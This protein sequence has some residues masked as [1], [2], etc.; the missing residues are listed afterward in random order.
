MLQSARWA[1]DASYEDISAKTG[2]KTDLLLGYEF[3]EITIPVHHLTALAHAVQQD[4]SYF[5]A[6]SGVNVRRKYPAPRGS[7]ATNDDDTYLLEFAADNRNRAVIR[8]AMAL[9]DIDRA[10][11]DRIASALLAIIQDKRDDGGRRQP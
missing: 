1:Q 7:M 10:K 11:L 2:L 3:G 9:R 8:L 4:P 5:T 6:S